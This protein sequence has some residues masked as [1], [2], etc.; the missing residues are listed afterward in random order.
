MK[1]PTAL[2]IFA[3]LLWYGSIFLSL[4]YDATRPTSL[5]PFEGRVFSQ[6]NHGHV[7][8][9][10]AEENLRIDLLDWAALGIFMVGFLIQHVQ[11]HPEF[12]QDA[13]GVVLR[14]FYGFLSP[15]GWEKGFSSAWQHIARLLQRGPRQLLRDAHAPF[16]RRDQKLSFVVA[17][18]VSE[19]QTRIRNA[20]G[21]A[22]YGYEFS[23]K[24]NLEFQVWKRIRNY[25][26]SFAPVLSGKLIEQ[27]NGTRIEGNFGPTAVVKGMSRIWFGL[28]VVIG[29]QLVVRG[30]E[31]VSWGT[32]NLNGNAYVGIFFPPLLLFVGWLIVSCGKRLSAD[33]QVE[34]R[35]LLE[36]ILGVV[37]R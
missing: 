37:S 36:K 2:G 25:W 9:L 27:T 21:Y 13:N 29:G 5:Q 35:A 28:V 31:D 30:I 33:E 18:D 22:T 17:Y 20:F 11:E 12:K 14:M 4:E 10:T 7:V 6:N 23:G 15:A 3:L 16:S 19:C 32:Q 34:I 24:H 1:V 26:N 8:Y